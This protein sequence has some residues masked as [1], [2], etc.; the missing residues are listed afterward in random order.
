MRGSLGITVLFWFG[1]VFLDNK[2]NLL[3]Y[4]TR[5]PEPGRF[6]IWLF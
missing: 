4:A 1:L 5:G 3:F 2:E 6:H